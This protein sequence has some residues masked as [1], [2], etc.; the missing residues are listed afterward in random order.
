LKNPGLLFALVMITFLTAPCIFVFPS[1]QAEVSENTWQEMAPMPTARWLFGLANADGKIFAIGGMGQTSRSL[2]LNINEMYDPTSD[3]WT[4]K[5]PMPTALDSFGITV[6]ENRLYCIG[7]E[8]GSTIVNTNVAYDVASDTWSTN[9]AMPTARRSM[10]ANVV[11]GKI[12][13]I[14]GV[15]GSGPGNVNEV[16]DIAMGN[17]S[18]KAPIPTRVS[19]YTSA[20][21]GSKIY[22]MGG[23]WENIYSPLFDDSEKLIQVYDCDTDTWITAG[24]L[25]EYQKGLSTAATLGI[26]APQ[27]IYSIGSNT[28]IYTPETNNWTEGATSRFDRVYASATVLNDLVYV[29]GGIPNSNNGS[30]YAVNERYTP[31]GFSGQYPESS[32]SS[33]SSVVIVA[34]VVVAGTVIAVTGVMV[35]HFKHAPAKAAKSV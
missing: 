20:V 12:Y 19:T 23:G 35:Y 21:I 27:K 1:V 15:T 7:G 10:T 31:F 6:W 25:P 26:F 2:S 17:W 11:D 28:L 8:S 24:N 16:Y 32:A 5:Q 13:V 4:T 9:I 3:T 18:T 29:M 22:I 34:G 30:V 33:L 14:G